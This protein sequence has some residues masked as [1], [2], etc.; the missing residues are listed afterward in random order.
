M[1]ALTQAVTVFTAVFFTAG[2]LI[3]LAMAGHWAVRTLRG[4]FTGA[5]THKPPAGASP[6]APRT[7]ERG[8]PGRAP[9]HHTGGLAYLLRRYHCG[10][11]HYYDAGGRLVHASP[12]GPQATTDWDAE[13]RRLTP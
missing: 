12:C 5:S 3:P 13:L 7:P 8:R 9:R 1:S 6:R 4:R 2:V 10:C 11:K